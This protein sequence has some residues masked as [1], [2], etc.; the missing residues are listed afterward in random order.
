MKNKIA[1]YILTSLIFLTASAYA[2][3]DVIITSTK[4]GIVD[5]T[6]ALL[7]PENQI[8][9]AK[10]SC[11]ASD[12]LAWDYTTEHGKMLYSTALAGHITGT[13]MLVGYDPDNCVMGNRLKLIKIHINK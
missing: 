9:E 3:T 12:I 1:I 10:P 2:T 8:I 11:A 5:E 13:E 6:Y 4:V 7:I